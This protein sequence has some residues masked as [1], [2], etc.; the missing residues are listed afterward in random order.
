MRESPLLSV[1]K[2]L[3]GEG[4]EVQIYDQNVSWSCVHG[5]NK[6]FAESEIPHIASLLRP[7]LEQVVKSADLIVIGNSDEEYSAI[8]GW[9]RDDQ[10]VLDFARLPNASAYAEG[11]CW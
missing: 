7:N 6:H 10:I 9:L 8:R 2:R 5:A 1:V 11:L 3:L 4:C